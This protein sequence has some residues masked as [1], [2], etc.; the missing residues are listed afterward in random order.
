MDGYDFAIDQASVSRGYWPGGGWSDFPDRSSSQSLSFQDVLD[1]VSGR[2]AGAA[3]AHYVQ[4]ADTSA[5]GAVGAT[6]QSAPLAKSQVTARLQRYT[7]EAARDID[8]RGMNAF[9][10]PQQIAIEQHPQLRAAYRG[11]Q[12]DKAVRAR[13]EKD[14]QLQGRLVGK[15]NKGPDFT[16]N[17]P[18]PDFVDKTTGAEYEVGTKYDMTTGKAFPA[19]QAKYGEDLVHLDTSGKVMPRAE[20]DPA[21]APKTMEPAPK[22]PAL[23]E[24]I[25]ELPEMPEIP[26]EIPL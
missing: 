15:P 21:T 14:P 10:N 4:V 18:G 19:H 6:Q 20:A 16:D 5:P 3:G 2:S 11:Y 25:P 13:V 8:A 24:E 23:P 7:T 17:G 9:T 12:I 26:L 1:G 22:T